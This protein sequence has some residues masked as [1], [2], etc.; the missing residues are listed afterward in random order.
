MISKNKNEKAT[1]EKSREFGVQQ[2]PAATA[3]SSLN[4]SSC[5][6]VGVNDKA[7]SSHRRAFKIIGIT[8]S[9]L[10][11]LILVAYVGVSVYFIDHFMPNSTIA[12]V[13]VSLMETS[14]AI[15]ALSRAV[16]TYSLSVIG[17]GFSLKVAPSQLGLSIDEDATVKAA[18]ANTY[19][20]AWPFEIGKTHIAT[21]ICAVSYDKA[22]LAKAIQNGVETFNETATPPKDARVSY[23]SFQHAFV[24]E[25]EVYGTLLDVDA[26]TT[27]VNNAVEVLCPSVKLTREQTQKPSVYATDE[28]LR[29]AAASANAAVSADFLLT[30]AG[31]KVCKVDSDIISKWIVFDG[32][33]A[34]LD[35]E[36]LA[37]WVDEISASCTSV[38]AE[39]TYTRSD[40]KNITV[41]GGSYGWEV[42]NKALLEM[43]KTAVLQGS[44]QNVE[45]PVTSRG[46]VFSG[47]G[48][49]DWPVRYCDVDLSEQYVR[50]YDEAGEVIWESSCVS[51]KPNGV[52]DTPTGVY[53]VNAKASPAKLRGTN[54][55][56]SKY[57][58]TVRYWMAFVGNSIGLH[59]ADWQPIFGGTWYRDG[60]GSHGCVNLPPQA[61]GGL[62][63]IIE[64]GDVV[65]THW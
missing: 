15:Q 9:V 43:I 60:G 41:S 27:V 19:P 16:D 50:F 13:D 39:R 35:D 12:K 63:A 29:V 31:S 37:A 46:A 52:C 4:S 55:D 23:N 28:S 1:I 20:W 10:M 42:D 44:T 58:S 34:S 22:A 38:G 2:T 8:L 40:G 25:P 5:N 24:V 64:Q 7:S 47:S 56:G 65:V 33:D 32:A 36:M 62:Y 6:D 11:A 17:E 53:C 3:A 14:D 21:E 51:G 54:L 48:K 45:V 26:V 18:L 61:A 49:R 57:E 59:D 30:L